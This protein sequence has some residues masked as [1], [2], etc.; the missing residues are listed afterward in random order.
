MAVTIALGRT[1]AVWDGRNWCVS[2][3]GE[4]SKAFPDGWRS[5]RWFYDTPDG[6]L[7]KMARLATND[8]E[9]GEI[10]PAEAVCAMRRDRE[11][12]AREAK[13][14]RL[15]RFPAGADDGDGDGADDGDGAACSDVSQVSRAFRCSECGW[16]VTLEDAESMEPTVLNGAGLAALPRFCP[17]CGREIDWAIGAGD[18]AGDD[19]GAD[20]ADDG[21]G[22]GPDD[23]ADADGGD[24]EGA[25]GAEI[26]D[27]R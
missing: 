27:A 11:A 20:D 5:P 19:A 21:A 24:T 7:E 6:A 8:W 15:P 4:P 18:D 17:G 1:R 14:V 13:K 16:R 10:G 12:L 26:L 25:E 22:A 23:A 2:M 3:K 9:D